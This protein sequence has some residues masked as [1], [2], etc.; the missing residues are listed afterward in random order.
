MGVLI[1]YDGSAD[2]PAA[3]AHAGQLMPGSDATI[4]VIWERASLTMIRMANGAWD[5]SPQ[6]A[7]TITDRALEK[8][9][10]KTASDRV[11]RAT[12][13][14]LM[15]QPRIVNR[16][17]DIAAAI[18]AVAGDV[19]ADVIVGQ[20]R[21]TGPRRALAATGAEPAMTRH[22]WPAALRPAI[23]RPRAR[24]QESWPWPPVAWC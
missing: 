19:D 1:G 24:L 15:A 7:T 20:G 4:L 9:A 8:A 14:G 21:S 16:H 17:D 5:W 18:L 11:R 13:A 23:R 2:A 3:V 10:L 6:T 22:R 12:A